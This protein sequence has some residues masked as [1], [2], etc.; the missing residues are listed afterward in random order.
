[1]NRFGMQ[2][3]CGAGLMLLPTLVFCSCSSYIAKNAARSFQARDG[4]VSVTV[5][6]VHVVKGGTREHDVE[7]AR[8]V[9]EFLR[10]ENLAD[11]TLDPTVIE[12]P[13][14][15]RIDQ[16]K[17]AQESALAFAAKVKEQG[18]QTDYALLGE[19]LCVP[20]ES[21]VVGVH[22]FLADRE[23]LLASG[24][25]TNSHWEEFHDV[26]PV[27]RRGGGE[28]LTRMIKRIWLDR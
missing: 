26:K 21:L 11:P 8:H 5:F 3:R 22:Y 12:I 19:I 13:V 6:P 10:A 28:V 27:D 1:M 24:G 23:G 2:I 18:I 4:V 17:M 15:W 16:S 25:L 20:D 14:H 9:A 7:L